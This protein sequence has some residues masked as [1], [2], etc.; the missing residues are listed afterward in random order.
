MLTG[1]LSGETLD[2]LGIT[3]VPRD[4]EES[5]TLP[6]IS[7]GIYVSIVIAEVVELSK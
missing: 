1:Y 3:W 7:G 5:R 4:T 2:A 6:R